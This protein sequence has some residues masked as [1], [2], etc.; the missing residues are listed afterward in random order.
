M[1]KLSKAA[2]AVQTLVEVRDAIFDATGSA[3]LAGEKCKPED[4]GIIYRKLC[5][6]GNHADAAI[7]L[8]QEHDLDLRSRLALAAENEAGL[9]ELLSEAID[10]LKTC[11]GCDLIYNYAEATG[12]AEYG[13]PLDP[14]TVGDVVDAFLERHAT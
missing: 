12:T 10:L 2:E 5:E 7:E 4:R 9:N 13:K 3:L 14:K 8:V 11:R 6:A 1:T